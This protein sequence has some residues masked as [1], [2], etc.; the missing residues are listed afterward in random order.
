ME[1]ADSAPAV[2]LPPTLSATDIAVGAGEAVPR[3]TLA[4]RKGFSWNMRA[5]RK[6]GKEAHQDS[7]F[8]IQ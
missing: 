5:H 6:T 1:S 4:A 2:M 3:A 7:V 8:G